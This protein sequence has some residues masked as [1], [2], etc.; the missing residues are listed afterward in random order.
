MPAVSKA[1]RRFFWW[2]E[3]DPEAEKRAGVKMTRQQMHDFATTPE[4]GLP[5][6]KRSGIG[7]YKRR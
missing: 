4:K 2:L 5:E 3:H 1:Q 6:K 7:S